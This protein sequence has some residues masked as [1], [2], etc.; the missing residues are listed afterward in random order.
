VIELA[1]LPFDA[2]HA[3]ALAG[4]LEAE[5]LGVYD[6][7]PGSG[8]LPAAEVFAPPAGAFVVATEDG[9][10]IGCG[11]LARLDAATGELRRMYVAPQA[12]GRGLGRMLLAE[13]ERLAAAS[14]YRRL[15]M[16]T[17]NLQAAAIA[18][19]EGAG[20]RRIDCWGPFVTDPRSICFEKSLPGATAPR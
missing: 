4:R 7:V 12:R 9:I 13:L 5:L 16:E 17:G 8:G 20:Y 14:G 19:Y 15:R 1:T 3:A 10:P 6:G 2:P 18:L 11:G